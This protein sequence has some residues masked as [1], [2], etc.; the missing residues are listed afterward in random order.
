MEEL[1]DSIGST[2]KKQFNLMSYEFKQQGRSAVEGWLGLKNSVP[3]APVV[4]QRQREEIQI[5]IDEMEDQINIDVDY[6]ADV[7]QSQRQIG[8]EVG[9]S[10][11]A[12]RGN[13]KG[14]AQTKQQ[15]AALSKQ[16]LELLKGTQI[17][18]MPQ[19]E[20]LNIDNIQ[21]L[22]KTQRWS[23]YLFWL[24]LFRSNKE[25]EI[26]T[27]SEEYNLQC[28]R[29][30][31]VKSIEELK[32]LSQATVIGMT[33]TGAAKYS[34]LLEEIKPRIVVVEEAAEVLEAHII[35]SLTQ[36]TQHLILIGDHKQLRPN[37]TCYNLSQSYNLDVSLFERMVK[38]GMKCE[39]LDIQHRMRPEIS[40]IL[41]HIYHKLE[42]HPKVR[43]YRNI[44]GVKHNMF[45]INHN[46]MED[47]NENNQNLKSYSNM[48]EAKYMVALCEYFLNQGYRPEE[49]TLLTMYAGQLLV[50][51]KLMPKERFQ[52]VRVTAVDNFQGEENKIILLS[53]V[54]SNTKKK[55]GFLGSENRICVALSR[56]QEGF[57]CIGN[58]TMLAEKSKLWKKIVEDMK[59]WEAIGDGMELVCMNHPEKKIC[60]KTAED[61]G[62]VPE[63]GCLEP[64]SYRLKCGHE[65]E[66]VCHP[67]DPDHEQYKCRKDCRELLCSGHETRCNRKCHFG[68]PCIGCEIKVVKTIP[69]CGHEVSVPCGVP[70]ESFQCQ[71]Q[72]RTRFGCRHI[73]PKKCFEECDPSDCKVKPVSIKAQIHGVTL[74]ATL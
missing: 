15:Y 45:F 17:K 5:P 20:A 46:V 22:N 14:R 60:A 69:K 23:L 36:E 73:C 31:E 38:G 11:Q 25:D 39:S 52:G 50:L 30:A 64:C 56:A 35:T 16:E 63:G 66:R 49:I 40:R 65:C 70:P 27:K 47:N 8:D 19:R 3:V 42:D 28:R 33:T 62:N 68:T 48:H 43:E 61:F 6:D 2:H 72:C 41:R 37:P 44:P 26:K 13:N 55:I 57:F 1:K 21:S 4:P 32:V 53:F 74:L 18:P 58:F 10:K 67:V 7:I 59:T 24:R 9:Y 54:R 51:R 29:L 12:P 71:E 34:K